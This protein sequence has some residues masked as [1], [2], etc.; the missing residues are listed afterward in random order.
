MIEGKIEEAG[1][2]GRRRKQLLDDFN[3]ARRYRRLKRQHYITPCG[4]LALE[5]VM[6]LS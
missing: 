2:R 5:E 1:K 3:E 6:D 4:V